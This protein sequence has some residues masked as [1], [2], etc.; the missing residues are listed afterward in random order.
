[1]KNE[2]Q[3]IKELARMLGIANKT[4]HDQMQEI[5]TLNKLAVY[6]KISIKNLAKMYEN[7]LESQDR[8][9][10]RLTIIQHY[11]EEKTLK[12]YE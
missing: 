6:K 10:H 5:D 2:N 12:V 11:L 1:M 9:I 4:I 3:Q 8:E 7:Q